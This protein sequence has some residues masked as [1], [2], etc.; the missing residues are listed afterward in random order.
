[1][2]RSARLL[3]HRPLPLGALVAFAMTAATSAPAGEDAADA[4]APAR[5]LWESFDG[6]QFPLSKWL[7]DAAPEAAVICVHG[8]SGA[9][10]DYSQL[11]ERLSSAGHAV[12]A[13]E[14]RGQGNDPDRDRLGDIKAREH[15]FADLDTFVS[16]VRA[17]H[18]DRPVFLYGESLGSLILMH[19]FEAMAAE[20]RAAVRGLVY[21]SPVV[22][23]PGELPPVKNFLVHALIKICPG[24]KVSVVRLA[25][26]APAQVTGDADKDHWDQM[27]ETPHFVEHLTFRMLGTMEKMVKSCAAAAAA[28]DRP[29]LVVHPGKD[30]FTTPNEVADFFSSLEAEDKTR[31][32]FEESHHLLFYDK[33]R[34]QLFDLV[35]RWVEE[36]T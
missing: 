5:E 7:P 11:G 9:A 31:H 30:V 13:Y 23:L 6:A 14:L 20:N 25:G 34:E 21:G 28:I 27:R 16:L 24:V 33:E 1:M 32:L 10:A 22:A 19:G 17:R 2:R 12:Y 18:P 4:G 26:D 29:V 3:L 15:W 8:L 36:R 35:E